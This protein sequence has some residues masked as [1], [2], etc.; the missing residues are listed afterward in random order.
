MEWIAGFAWALP[1][2][3]SAAVSACR[4]EQGDV[5]CRERAACGRWGPEDVPVGPVLQVLDPP[6]SARAI[7]ADAE[8]SR[9]ETGWDSPVTLE[10]YEAGVEGPERIETT[11][12]RLY[13]CLWRGAA[14]CLDD[15]TPPPPPPRGLRELHR[16]LAAAVPTF[17]GR[18]ARRAKRGGHQLLIVASDDA[19]DA[20]RVKVRAIQGLLDE[21]FEIEACDL[22]PT[23]AGVPEAGTLRPSLL[24]R[25]IAIAT[26]DGA[27]IEKCLAGLLYGGSS[28]D[29]KRFSV[30]RH[31]HLAPLS[32]G[33]TPPD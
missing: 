30:S 7:A 5:L 31:G 26:P 21:A 27:A 20:T 1:R 12:G 18:F 24:L 16:E 19:I 3:L 10:R 25:G 2:A 15:S 4:F 13:T 22:S 6:R 32:G 9:F 28:E 8:G 29:A 17:R 11:Q 33:A 14:D 23:E